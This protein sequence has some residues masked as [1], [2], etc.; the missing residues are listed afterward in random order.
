MNNTSLFNFDVCFTSFFIFKTMGS[1]LTVV[2]VARFFGKDAIVTRCN[3]Q[4]QPDNFS[5][6]SHWRLCFVKHIEGLKYIIR[7]LTI[8]SCIITN[9]IP[10]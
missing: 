2:V 6:V 4:L 3:T 9:Q 10:M 1:N 5:L 7:M 8:F